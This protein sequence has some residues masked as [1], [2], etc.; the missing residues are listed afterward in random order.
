MSVIILPCVIVSL[1]PN[2]VFMG[3]N[4]L[5]FVSSCAGG[6]ALC[7]EGGGV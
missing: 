7:C 1:S 2:S 5:I 4:A 6:G 3:G